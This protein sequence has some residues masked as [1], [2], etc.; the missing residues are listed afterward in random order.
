ML[1]P[2]QNPDGTLKDAKD[3]D[4][5]K[6]LDSALKELSINSILARNIIPS[7]ELISVEAENVTE[8][9]WTDEDIVEQVKFNQIEAEGGEVEELQEPPPLVEEQRLSLKE[10]C[11]M[12]TRLNDFFRVRNGGKFADAR[13]LLTSVSRDLRA[14]SMASLQQQGIGKY[15]IDA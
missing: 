14:E 10:A 5:I 2:A 8:A 6:E 7:A 9:E 11:Q 13:K 3:I 4:A 1:G 15:F 12:M